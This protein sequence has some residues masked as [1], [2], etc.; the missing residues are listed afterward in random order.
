[1][2]L[3]GNG[4]AYASPV[5]ISKAAMLKYAPA[6][7]AP[8]PAINASAAPGDSAFSTSIAVA[9]PK[10]LIAKYWGLAIQG[11][12]IT[13]TIKKLENKALRIMSGMAASD[14]V[15]LSQGDPKTS[16]RQAHK[17]KAFPV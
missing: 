14:V 13:R 15:A 7:A 16:L 10:M 3:A 1:M 5:A 2:S 8:F 6:N 4:C 9:E 17:M 12:L 11:P